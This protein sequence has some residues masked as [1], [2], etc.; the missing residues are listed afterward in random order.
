MRFVK[1]LQEDGAVVAMAGDGI[2][3]HAIATADIGLAMGEGGT[4]LDGDSRYS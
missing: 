3:M 1:Q 4:G 2:M